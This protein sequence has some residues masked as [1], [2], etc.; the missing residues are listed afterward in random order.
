[1]GSDFGQSKEWD[2]SNSLD[3]HLLEYNEHKGIQK[4]IR[5]LNQLYLKTPSPYLGDANSNLFEWIAC[6]DSESGVIAF[7]RWDDTHDDHLIIVA[8]FT[9]IFRESYRSAFLSTAFIK[10][11]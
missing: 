4:L 11:S 6:S 2:Y 9:P 8:H 10:K 1:M 5:D 3:W 7:I